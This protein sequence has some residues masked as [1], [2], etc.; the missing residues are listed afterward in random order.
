MHK[1]KKRKQRK[2]NSTDKWSISEYFIN[3]KENPNSED[4]GK[5]WE[6]RYRKAGGC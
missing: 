4:V 6:A 3:D 2:K 1:E 5:T